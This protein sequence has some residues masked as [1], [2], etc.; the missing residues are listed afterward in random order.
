MHTTMT[1]ICT[2][3]YM[4]SESGSRWEKASLVCHQGILSMS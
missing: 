3:S 1:R 2:C 4:G